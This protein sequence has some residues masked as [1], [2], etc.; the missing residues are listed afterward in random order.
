[1]AETRDWVHDV[2]DPAMGGMKSGSELDDLLEV[3]GRTASQVGR[4]I[5]HHF[6]PAENPSRSHRHVSGGDELDLT[7]PDS[8]P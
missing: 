3:V 5:L 7:S 6:K 2:F 4:R 8:L 1:M